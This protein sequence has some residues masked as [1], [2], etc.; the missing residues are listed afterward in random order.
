MDM[1]KKISQQLGDRS[2]AEVTTNTAHS[3]VSGGVGVLFLLL[4]AEAGCEPHDEALKGR[5]ARERSDSNRSKPVDWLLYS[6]A[7]RFR[8]AEN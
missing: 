6:P 7:A 5:P 3:H 1:K 8:V 4:H 2:P